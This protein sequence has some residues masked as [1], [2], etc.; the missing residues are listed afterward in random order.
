MEAKEEKEE[1][2]V[3]GIPFR[4]NQDQHIAQH[5]LP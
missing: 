3:D 5:L 1:E 4:G 2:E